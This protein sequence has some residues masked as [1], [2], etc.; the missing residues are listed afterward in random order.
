MSLNPTAIHEG[1]HC[2]VGLL[3]GCTVTSASLHSDGGG[4]TRFEGRR[5]HRKGV[6]TC[7]AGYE[8]EKLLLGAA[9]ISVARSAKDFRQAAE[10]ALAVAMTSDHV[11]AIRRAN[12][13]ASR[14]EPSEPAEPSTLH[15]LPKRVLDALIKERVEAL[16]ARRA[17]RASRIID[18]AEVAVRDLLRANRCVL[19]TI[20]TRLEQ[21][22]ELGEDELLALFREGQ[23]RQIEDDRREWRTHA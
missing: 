9:D 21:V 5:S 19:R 2:T 4:A 17:A 1:G 13:A 11:R 20:A 22:G 7:L 16:Y 8:A 23:R 3:T 14:G 10:H 18:A 12:E 6:L 15:T